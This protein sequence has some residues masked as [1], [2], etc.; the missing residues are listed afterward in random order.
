MNISEIMKALEDNTLRTK[1]LYDFSSQEIQILTHEGDVVWGGNVFDLEES[2][3]YVDVIPQL[4]E[5]E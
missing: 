5:N 4:Q 1:V 2:E 3:L